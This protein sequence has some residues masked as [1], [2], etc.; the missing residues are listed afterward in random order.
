M[1]NSAA[2]TAPTGVVRLVIRIRV[3]LRTASIEIWVQSSFVLGIGS[4]SARVA[5]TKGV[6]HI[7]TSLCNLI[8][9]LGVFREGMTV[10]VEDLFADGLSLSLFLP[11]PNAT[12]E[13]GL[14]MVSCVCKKYMV[15]VYHCP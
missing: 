15:L 9:T 7:Q 1:S 8:P 6:Y 13:H 12:H 14:N 2:K 4:I 10:I 3:A 5:V 11:C